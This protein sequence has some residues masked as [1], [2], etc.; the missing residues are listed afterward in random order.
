MSLPTSLCEV[1]EQPKGCLGLFHILNNPGS[2]VGLKAANADSDR[3]NLDI[4]IG[5]SPCLGI[6]SL[7]LITL[8]IGVSDSS[9]SGVT[10]D[11]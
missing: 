6:L 5:Y 4:H 8:I 9:M 3:S 2:S 10:I 11:V 7:P 1:G